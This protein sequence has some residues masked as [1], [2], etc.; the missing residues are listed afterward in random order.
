M[1]AKLLV[2][3]LLLSSSCGTLFSPSE[4]TLKFT[5]EPSGATV[6]LDGEIIG[7]TPLEYSLDRNIAQHEALVKL[8]KYPSQTIL[9]GKS[10]NPASI[11]NLTS[12]LSWATDLTSGNVIQ[13][14]PKAYFV[15]LKNRSASTDESKFRKFV[16]INHKFILNDLSKNKG[17][18][19]KQMLEI[20][21]LDK[22][23]Q[24]KLQHELKAE[25]GKLSKYK[26]PNEL[27]KEI[28]DKIVEIK[29]G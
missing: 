17:E 10:V 16:L 29:N 9:I 21:S 15:D 2:L 26:W 19:L 6:Y 22:I 14:S 23:Q 11:F 18:H 8:D 12:I 27:L 28:E 24:S 25:I 5:S 7:K 3:V 13:Y 4:D 1:K 20:S